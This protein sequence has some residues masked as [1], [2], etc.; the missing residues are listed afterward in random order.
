MLLRRVFMKAYLIF[1]LCEPNFYRFISLNYVCIY[2]LQNC[3]QVFLIPVCL[4]VFLER[5][6]LLLL[7]YAVEAMMWSLHTIENCKIASEEHIAAVGFL[8]KR[9]QP[10]LPGITRT[11]TSLK[12]M[13]TVIFFIIYS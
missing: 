8:L 6:A 7:L 2:L 9:E 4:Y 5:T 12:Y 13:V 11:R 1:L 3:L 10:G